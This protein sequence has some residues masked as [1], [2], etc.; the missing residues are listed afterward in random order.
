[1]WQRLEGCEIEHC[2]HHDDDDYKET[3]D[4]A[5]DEA[6]DDDEADNDNKENNHNATD[7]D[8]AHHDSADHNNNPYND[9][10]YI[11]VGC[12]RISHNI[13][14][15]DAFAYATCDS[16][17]DSCADANHFSKTFAEI[18]PETRASFAATSYS[19][20]T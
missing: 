13:S 1:M 9:N 18:G 17:T 5:D 11:L 16:Q 12:S 4:E 7:N 14:T 3:D 8:S 15:W 10:R 19:S 6:D 20:A 2:W